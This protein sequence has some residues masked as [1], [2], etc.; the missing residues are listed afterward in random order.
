MLHEGPTPCGPL[1]AGL[2]RARDR[3][4][5]GDLN[6]ESSSADYGTTLQ[7]RNLGGFYP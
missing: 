7:L 3:G 6:A 4:G 5:L 1:R 2:A